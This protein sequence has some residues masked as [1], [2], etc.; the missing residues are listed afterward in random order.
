MQCLSRAQRLLLIYLLYESTKPRVIQ[1]VTKHYGGGGITE[2]MAIAAV[3]G[4][5][6]LDLTGV[7][8]DSAYP[9]ALLLDGSR[10]VAGNI[11]PDGYNTRML[12]NWGG[13]GTPVW[14]SVE[15]VNF[16]GLNYYV[17]GDIFPKDTSSE[18][19][20][21]AGNTSSWQ[22]LIHCV[23]DAG[24]AYADIP[25]AG[26]IS[27]LAGK[28]LRFLGDGFYTMI[29]FD[30]SY[31]FTLVDDVGT[32]CDLKVYDLY[33]E[34]ALIGLD[35]SF[36]LKS[37]Q[38]VNAYV[39]LTSWDGAAWQTPVFSKGGRAYLDNLPVADPHVVNQLWNDGGTVKVS[40][41]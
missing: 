36:H 18:F 22:G 4:E 15:S 11:L 32:L 28:E 8:P 31:L 17:R 27:L 37:K 13:V 39:S 7:I 38:D 12:G 35:D 19:W 29:D 23:S 26:D 3:E 25:R 41:G 6:T 21:Y 9:N 10:A 2:A 33:V 16:E 40:A 24:G 1:K 5:A 30:G 20:L 34:D 14:K